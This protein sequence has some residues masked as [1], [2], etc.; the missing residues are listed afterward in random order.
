MSG[1]APPASARKAAKRAAEASPSGSPA[2]TPTKPAKRTVDNHCGITIGYHFRATDKH[3]QLTKAAG[4]NRD[5]IPEPNVFRSHI[6]DIFGKMIHSGMIGAHYRSR[7]KPGMHFTEPNSQEPN[8]LHQYYPGHG[9]HRNIGD[10]TL[11]AARFVEKTK[12]YIEKHC[13]YDI[14]VDT[15]QYSWGEQ[16]SKSYISSM[17]YYAMPDEPGDD[18]TKFDTIEEYIAHID[19]IQSPDNSDDE[20]EGPSGEWRA[21]VDAAIHSLSADVRSINAK[22]DALLAQK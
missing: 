1:K 18:S 20:E 5:W 7:T 3:V 9:N 15:Q 6:N 22:L 12:A 4:T 2:Q 11:P 8:P 16:Q 17:K 14:N 21:S 19:S 13:K 10:V